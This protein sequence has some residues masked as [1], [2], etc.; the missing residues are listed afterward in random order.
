MGACYKAELYF[1]GLC[2]S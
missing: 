2:E 1:L